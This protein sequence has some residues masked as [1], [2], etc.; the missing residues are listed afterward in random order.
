MLRPI[1]LMRSQRL[2]ERYAGLARVPARG[3]LDH[4]IGVGEQQVRHVEAERLGDL[5]I[6]RA[7]IWSEAPEDLT[8]PGSFALPANLSIASLAKR[9]GSRF[10]TAIAEVA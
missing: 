9:H 7:H 2:Y 10:Y 5:E 8:R 6:N 3:S 1:V 4:L